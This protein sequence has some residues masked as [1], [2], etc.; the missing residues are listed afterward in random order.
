[1]SNYNGI[2]EMFMARYGAFIQPGELAPCLANP[3]Y[4]F[5]SDGMYK[6]GKNGYEK[7]APEGW[8]IAEL[9]QELMGE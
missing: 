3:A 2:S 5:A 7:V 9:A 1:V 6:L 8:T 4:L